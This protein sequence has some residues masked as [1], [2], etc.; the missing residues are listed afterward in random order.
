[1]SFS[2]SSCQGGEE[3]TGAGSMDMMGI[4]YAFEAREEQKKGGGGHREREREEDEGKGERGER[5]HERRRSRNKNRIIRRTGML[6]DGWHQWARIGDLIAAID[7]NDD[8]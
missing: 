2:E 3:S 1:M 8:N 6:H 5:R 7:S 4:V